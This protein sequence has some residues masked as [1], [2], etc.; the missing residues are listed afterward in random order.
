MFYLAEVK[1][2]DMREE[3]LGKARLTRRKNATMFLPLFS[4]SNV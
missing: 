3:G 2:E 1:K 4:A